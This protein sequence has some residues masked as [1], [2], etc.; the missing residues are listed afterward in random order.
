MRR[1]R[2]RTYVV[3]LSV[4]IG[5]PFIPDLQPRLS[6]LRGAPVDA[7]VLLR[8]GTLHLGDGQ[9]AV[10]GDL[11]IAGERIVAIGE[12]ETSTTRKVIDCRGLV[13]SPGFIDLHNHSDRQ[14]LQ[15]DTRAVVNYLT[16]GCTTI[17]TGNLMYRWFR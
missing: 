15:R 14:V 13:V 4:L 6:S 3:I 1:D 11:A 10:V 9:P 16:Q 7:D 5:F 8:G 17:V 12:F 2:H